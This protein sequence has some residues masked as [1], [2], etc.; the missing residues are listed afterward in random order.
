LL[1]L[2]KLFGGL[3]CQFGKGKVESTEFDISEVYVGNKIILI[4]QIQPGVLK[5]K[6]NKIF[7]AFRTSRNMPRLE[8][9]SKERIKAMLVR[10][11]L[12][13]LLSS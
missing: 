12:Q 11:C 13:R 8:S 6:H 2:Q 5:I 7:G 3:I 1:N 4:E 9:I 10:C